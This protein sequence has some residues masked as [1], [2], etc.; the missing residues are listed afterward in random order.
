MSRRFRRLLLLAALAAGAAAAPRAAWAEVDVEARLSMGSIEAG[1]VV[2]LLVTV[3]DPRGTI[4]DP[5]FTLPA[6]LELLGSS[7]EQQFKWVNGRSTTQV[8]FR[9]ELGA[10]RAGN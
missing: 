8:S 1:G 6:G 9:F 3:T 4:S 7:R 10:S 2:A 5:Q